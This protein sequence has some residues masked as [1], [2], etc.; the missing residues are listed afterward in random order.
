[1]ALFIGKRSRRGC[2]QFV[3]IN[4]H[5]IQE[6]ISKKKIFHTTFKKNPLKVLSDHKARNRS[7]NPIETEKSQNNLQKIRF[8]FARKILISRDDRSS[9][10]DRSIRAVDFAFIYL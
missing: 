4:T 1:M 6:Q 5:I 7:E 9:S 3:P 8:S 2:Q 10:N